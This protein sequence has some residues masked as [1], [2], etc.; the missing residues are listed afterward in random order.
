MKEDQL[1]FKKVSLILFDYRILLFIL[2]LIIFL[3][4]RNIKFSW[5]DDGYNLLISQ[6]LIGAL[7]HVDYK[8]LIGLFFETENGRFRPLYWIW[9]S[10]FFLIGGLNP[11]IHYLLH[12][13]FIFITSLYLYKTVFFLSKSKISGLF[14][15]ALFLTNSFNSE[16]WYRLGPQEPILGFLLVT[17]IY[18]LLRK[19]PFKAVFLLILTLFSKETSIIIIPATVILYL[20]KKIILKR[21]NQ[22]VKKYLLYGV[23]VGILI[24]YFTSRLKGGY[25]DSYLFNLNT[26]KNNF[27]FYFRICLIKFFPF[28]QI[29]TFSFILRYTYLLVSKGKKRLDSIFIYQL[30]F[31]AIFLGFLLIQSPWQFTLFRYL[32]PASIGLLIFSGLELSNLKQYLLKSN[33]LIQVLSLIIFLTLTFK[34]LSIN[35][36]TLSI[37]AKNYAQT[38]THFQKMIEY[39]S[40][41]SQKKQKIFFNLKRAESTIEIFKESKIY[42]NLLNNRGD[43]IINYYDLR[44]NTLDNYYVISGSL[45]LPQYKEE[46]I[47]RR[48]NLEL[49]KKIITGNDYWF[50]YKSKGPNDEENL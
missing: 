25:S 46:Q 16:N 32:L 14:S 26:I 37:E 9:Q 27:L 6:K 36:T 3:P 38:T 45:F 43:I 48:Q 40:V 4:A 39:L 15:A 24:I 29:F 13:I 5:I 47:Q 31:F 41:S 28:I 19:D 50:I 7:K 2:S 10:V 1:F 23:L 20:G 49:I 17:S 30:F 42:M 33:K 22:I 34:F 12:S 44:L 21:D 18:F 11:A 35:L 8:T